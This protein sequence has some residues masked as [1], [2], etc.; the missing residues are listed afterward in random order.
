MCDRRGWRG[1]LTVA[2]TK[3][4]IGRTVEVLPAVL[5]AAPAL[6]CELTSD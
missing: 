3:A 6:F 4:G 5:P 1:R 2:H